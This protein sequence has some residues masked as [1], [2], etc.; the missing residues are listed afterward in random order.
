[1]AFSLISNKS[2]H[3]CSMLSYCALSL[4]A[5]WWIKIGW[6]TRE[7]GNMAPGFKK[8]KKKKKRAAANC[9]TQCVKKKHSWLKLRIVSID[10][11]A[12]SLPKSINEKKM[13]II[14][15]VA[16]FHKL[17]MPRF[18]YISRY[19]GHC[20]CGC[21]SD[22]VSLCTHILVSLTHSH[23]RCTVYTSAVH[24]DRPDYSCFRHYSIRCALVASHTIKFLQTLHFCVALMS[25]NDLLSH[26]NESKKHMTSC[27]VVLI[28]LISLPA[29]WKISFT[30]F[31]YDEK[32]WLYHVPNWQLHVT[33]YNFSVLAF[34]ELYNDTFENT[35]IQ[36]KIII[37]E[38]H[39]R[40]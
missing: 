38:S 22:G 17:K 26:E 34:N 40:F 4:R 5:K 7:I 23:T 21:M 20:V 16:F 24:I 11:D 15:L 36:F 35:Q 37:F 30:F 29:T 32:L 2:V 6:R 12:I 33:G 8:K 28:Q 10:F 13:L 18:S 19:K 39:F 31:S 9:E 1:M 27:E 25:N 3:K 14:E